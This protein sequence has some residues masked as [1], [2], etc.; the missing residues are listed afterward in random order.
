MSFKKQKYVVVKKAI[1]KDLAFFIY[2]Y[3]LLKK[4]VAK[5][6]FESTHISPFETMFGV[7]TD[8]QVPNTYS[9]YADVVMETLLLKVQPIV[10]KQTG[11]NPAY[12]SKIC[13]HRG[14]IQDQ[15]F[16]FLH[17]LHF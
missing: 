1:T 17:P 14:G 3:F 10:E 6:L 4:Q 5:T 11:L 9:H 13:F 7:W 15:R 2:N 16:V 12:S 8:A